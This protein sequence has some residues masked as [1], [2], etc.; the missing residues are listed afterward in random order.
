MKF[1]GTTASLLAASTLSMA[2]MQ[3]YA[4][5]AQTQAE[6]DALRARVEALE[7]SNPVTGTGDLQ[8]GNTS[9]D[10]YGY[11]KA[12][13]FYDFEF[14]QGDTAFV[15]VIGE[16]SEAT[17]GTFGTTI[18]QSRI[19][20]RTN[21]PSAI[22]DIGGQLELDLFASGGTAELRLRHANI[23]IGDAWLIGQTWTNFMPLNTY[24][25]TV[26][27][28]GPVWYPLRPCSAGA[29]HQQ[30]GRQ[31]NLLCFDRTKRQRIQLGRSCCDSC[32]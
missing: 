32:R 23:T 11:V 6:L 19:G 2:G 17:S 8:I 21:T 20:L 29:L 27:F 14:D 12:D 26:E 16:P 18:R 7:T 22:G 28:N 15:N 9:L 5:D 1:K 25:T 13:F 4:Q 24:P 3:A 30:I 10:I 31:H